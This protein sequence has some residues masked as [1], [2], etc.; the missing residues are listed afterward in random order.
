M[1]KDYENC[2]PCGILRC[3][4]EEEVSC[5]RAYLFSDMTVE[6]HVPVCIVCTH[7]FHAFY[8]LTL[9]KKFIFY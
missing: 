6:Y 1:M 5:V 9:S 8:L 4:K 3:I 2:A 7:R